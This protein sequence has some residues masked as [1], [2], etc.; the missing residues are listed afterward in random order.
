MGVSVEQPQWK[1]EREK[2]DLQKK[3]A[4]LRVGS[5]ECFVTHPNQWQRKFGA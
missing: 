3:F 2:V 1:M 5:K 4:G